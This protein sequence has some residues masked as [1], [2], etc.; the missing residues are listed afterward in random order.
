MKQ[1]WVKRILAMI[2]ALL[3]VSG[4]IF[5]ALP[6]FASSTAKKE[7]NVIGI[8]VAL[9]KDYP[10]IIFYDV[11]G[12]VIQINGESEL[13]IADK[14]LSFNSY[15]MVYELSKS[16][17]IKRNFSSYDLIL[18]YAD[19]SYPLIPGSK[20]GSYKNAPLK[21]GAKAYIHYDGYE[22]LCDDIE[23]GVT[24]NDNLLI[25]AYFRGMDFFNSY[26]NKMT[27]S[28]EYKRA[29]GKSVSGG[30]EY[31]IANLDTPDKVADKQEELEDP[32]EDWIEDGDYLVNPDN[33]EQKISIDAYREFLAELWAQEEND[34]TTV[35]E[36]SP[37]IMNAS[38]P[39]VIVE[40]Y[41]FAGGCTQVTAGSDFMLSLNCINTHSK[42]DLENIIMKISTSDGLQL[43]S[44]SNTFFI[45]RLKRSAGFEKILEISALS[46]AE[47][48]SHVVSIA[49]E[50]EYVAD[51]ERKQGKM[52]QDISI[53]VVQADRFSADPIT[54]VAEIT[55]GEEIDIVS[56]YMNKSR[57]QLYNLTA[58]LLFDENEIGCDETIIHGGNLQAGSSGEMEFTLYGMMPGSF[59]AEILYTYEDA[60][61]NEK[62]TRVPFEVTF[63]E[64]PSF[65]WDQP[66]MEEFPMDGIMYDEFGNP[67]DM[68]AE[69][70]GLSQ[71]HLLM[72]GGGV[73]A[74][75]AI[76]AVIVRKRKQAKEFEDDDENF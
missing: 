71:T 73:V 26:E 13:S 10:K 23:F 42:I 25:K 72:I 53:P 9:V 74:A 15:E 19:T 14:N 8:K 48:K 44:S 30:N 70:N 75:V 5:G 7:E 39:Y 45:D 27:V 20:A 58:E 68:M 31:Y 28:F 56:K 37:V 12:E 22:F 60:M 34:T 3:M 18:C 63:V 65:E 50:Y 21:E 49:F 52:S 16:S 57:G 76:A 66:V 43:T 24:N 35:P 4:V 17:R 33:E 40:N 1:K 54:G 6:A 55:V 59:N 69:D 51:G 36:T 38:T 41:A 64:A 2:L 32:Y 61:G 47:A 46:A 62:E 29:D 11:D 67:I